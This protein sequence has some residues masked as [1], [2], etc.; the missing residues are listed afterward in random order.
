MM[1]SIRRYDMKTYTL[2]TCQGKLHHAYLVEV[3]VY[4]ESIVIKKN[5]TVVYNMHPR[6]INRICHHQPNN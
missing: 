6:R 5:S 3:A 4:L 1:I 2:D